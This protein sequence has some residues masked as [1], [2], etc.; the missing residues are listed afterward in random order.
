MAGRDWNGTSGGWGVSLDFHRLVMLVG[1]G[2]NPPP[3]ATGCHGV[4][5]KLMFSL[6]TGSKKGKEDQYEGLSHPFAYPRV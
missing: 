5:R 3:T 4:G 6:S 2:H 1:R